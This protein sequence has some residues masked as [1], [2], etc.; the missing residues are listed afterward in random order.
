MLRI[1]KGYKLKPRVLFTHRTQDL[2]I[3]VLAINGVENRDTE[4]SFISTSSLLVYSNSLGNPS[5]LHHESQK[6]I[7]R[8]G[9]Y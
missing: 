4:L 1:R 2:G 5:S 9:I 3:C 8:E 6:R 7:C